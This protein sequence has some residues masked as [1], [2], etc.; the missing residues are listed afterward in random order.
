MGGELGRELCGKAD[1]CGETTMSTLSTEETSWLEDQLRH[2]TA[3]LSLDRLTETSMVL[4][5]VGEC[6]T[7][8]D[9]PERKMSSSSEELAIT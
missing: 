9:L 1:A 8:Q 3:G 2:C 7:M 4:A 6:N 5:E